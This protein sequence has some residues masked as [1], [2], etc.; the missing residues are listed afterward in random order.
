MD[1]AMLL[2]KK[3]RAPIQQKPKKKPEPKP[4]S[5]KYNP[6]KVFVDSDHALYSI[7]IDDFIE[8]ARWNKRVH[9]PEF[10]FE[11]IKHLKYILKSKTRFLTETE[12]EKLEDSSYVEFLTYLKNFVPVEIVKKFFIK[13]Y[14]S[15]TD[16]PVNVFFKQY[17]KNT[18]ETDRI[19]RASQ[20]F[21]HS[22]KANPLLELSDESKKKIKVLEKPE[23]RKLITISEYITHTGGGK[24]K[25]YPISLPLR[26]QDKNSP[27]CRYEKM[28]GEGDLLSQC[29]REYKRAGWMKMFTDKIIRKFLTTDAQFA[30]E[31]K[32]KNDVIFE[33]QKGVKWY[34]VNKL[35]FKLSCEGKRKFVPNT[36]AYLTTNNEII[37]ETLEMFNESLKFDF[38]KPFKPITL[39]SFNV[40]KIM[41]MNNKIL[42][43]SFDETYLNTYVDEI[44]A[45]FSPSLSNHD[46]ARKLSYVLVFLT[47]L[48]H[49][50]QYHHKRVVER[51]ISGQELI[52]LDRYT[53]L[54][55]IFTDEKS[56]KQAI[57]NLI[58]KGRALIENTYYTLLDE[59]EFCPEAGRK[60]TIPQKMGVKKK[61][62]EL[63]NIVY[64]PVKSKIESKRSISDNVINQV[65]VNENLAPGLINKLITFIYREFITH[66][67]KCNADI[68]SSSYISVDDNEKKEF[69]NKECFEAYEFH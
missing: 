24:R 45:S 39:N 65:S 34:K 25:V 36:V 11:E 13:Y 40:A 27:F 10:T 1:N 26:Q 8:N 48:I 60:H 69:C 46:I 63:C 47:D 44:I 56:D 20:I 37:N 14:K 54:P 42:K 21:V 30:I 35:F 15:E 12:V 7:I 23:E 68:G 41:L 22:R 38:E 49:E 64:N 52:R 33:D 19:I 17:V 4:K 32:L 67:A 6:W 55:E 5:S 9:T 57:E 51:L 50:P 2:V 31:S 58:K 28:F 43:E 3:K 59:I 29:E 61:S 66:C 62:K 18:P 16:V 53:L